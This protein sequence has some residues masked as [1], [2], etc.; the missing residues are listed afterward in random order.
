MS[1]APARAVAAVAVIAVAVVAALCTLQTPPTASTAGADVQEDDSADINN[2]DVSNFVASAAASQTDLG[3]GRDCVIEVQHNRSTDD[4]LDSGLP[5]TAIPVLSTAL[6]PEQL[7]AGMVLHPL[8][9]PVILRLPQHQLH[10]D[11]QRLV[12]AVDR[13]NIARSSYRLWETAELGVDE[14]S[15]SF[16]PAPLLPLLG[17]GHRRV[18]R[19][20]YQGVGPGVQQHVDWAACGLAWQ[21]QLLGTKTWRVLSP[22][23]SDRTLFCGQTRPGDVLIYA[24]QAFHSTSASAAAFSSALQGHLQ[25]AAFNKWA[26]AHGRPQP[27]TENSPA[28]IARFQRRCV[29]NNPTLDEWTRCTSSWFSSSGCDVEE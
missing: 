20:L 26:V 10:P 9:R 19:G 17:R 15:L 21:L 7:L 27:V 16:F 23:A 14:D 3:L 4:T 11:F 29:A 18:Y 6:S 22:F 24:P 13:A 8:P 12:A 1:A 25:Y 28:F 5:C 2:P